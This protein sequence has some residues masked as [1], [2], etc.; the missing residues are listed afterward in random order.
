[1][2]V[3]NALIIPLTIEEGL[4]E[5]HPDLTDGHGGDLRVGVGPQRKTYLNALNARIIMRVKV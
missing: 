1:M 4:A 2:T 3:G 5:I